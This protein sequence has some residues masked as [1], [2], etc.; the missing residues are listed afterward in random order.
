MK[1]FEYDYNEVIIGGSIESL[2]FSCIFRI[3]VIL[4][5]QPE[6][7]PN[8]RVTEE[9]QNF[10]RKS[11]KEFN[12]PT[13]FYWRV[14]Q[15]KQ[16]IYDF[17][18]FIASMRGHLFASSVVESIRYL[19][20]DKKLFV[21]TEGSRSFF[22]KSNNFFIFNANEKLRDFPNNEMMQLMLDRVEDSDYN[23]IDL[24][25]TSRI[26][27]INIER[28]VPEDKICEEINIVNFNNVYCRT[29]LKQ[30]DIESFEY[31]T[32]IVSKYLLSVL[33]PYIQRYDITQNRHLPKLI[34]TTR[35]I[36]RIKTGD[37]KRIGNFI[38]DDR[39][40]CAILSIYSRTNRTLYG[41]YKQ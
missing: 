38:Y 9:E 31:S 8:D 19:E 15:K 29:I 18:C 37:K 20:E 41:T 12:V 11:F 21:V 17:L 30:K 2:L 36:K 25:K 13:L 40:F 32:I 5:D 10:L 7:L 16:F 26:Q 14:L 27:K 6:F 24:Y 34:H 23:V 33:K 28:L 22:V 39:E 4:I 35:S 3:P 1:K